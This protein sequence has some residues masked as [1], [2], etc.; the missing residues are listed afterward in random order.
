M[1]FIWLD[2]KL[3][4]KTVLLIALLLATSFAKD[5]MGR[6]SSKFS[7]SKNYPQVDIS[8]Y[9]ELEF[10][11]LEQSGDSSYYENTSEYKNLPVS[12]KVY[13]GFRHRLLLDIEGQINP[14]LYIRYK[15]MQEPDIPQETDIYVEYDKFSVYFGK[16]DASLKN[17]EIFSVNKNI[18]GI[19]ADYNG[20]YNQLKFIYGE[21][22]S[23]KK[24]FSFKGSGKKEYSLGQSN[25]LE[26]SLK[27]R[28]NGDSISDGDYA[29][30]YYEGKIIFNRI[31][32]VTE[33]VS[34]Y[35]EYLD[36]IEDFL[37]ISSKV[38]LQGIQ[39]QYQH[40]IVPQ[41]RIA[42]AAIVDK[43]I[44]ETT[45]VLENPL[46]QELADNAEA[47]YDM[48]NN[49]YIF[50]LGHSE[51][52]KVSAYTANN[53]KRI[54]SRN[55]DLF[56]SSFSSPAEEKN[57]LQLTLE[58][59][60]YS[61]AKDVSLSFQPAILTK[62]IEVEKTITENFIEAPI[63]TSS[64]VD[65]LEELAITTAID[66]V[67]QP[68]L[69]IV[70][71]RTI[72]ESQMVT[73]DSYVASINFQ[74][75]YKIVHPEGI[76]SFDQDV[77]VR[78]SMLSFELV[79]AV[80]SL[81]SVDVQF[82]SFYQ[83]ADKLNGR[84]YFKQELNDDFAIGINYCYL[85]VEQ[86]DKSKVSRRIVFYVIPEEIDY[87]KKINLTKTPIVSF[88]DTVFVDDIFL[89]NQ[90]DYKVDYNT[91]VLTFLN[92]N[93]PVSADVQIEYVYQKSIFTQEVFNGKDSKG[94]YEFSQKNIVPGT[95]EI[96]IGDIL[97]IEGIDYTVN[98]KKG[99]LGF[100][101]KISAIEQVVANYSYYEI[102]N[103]KELNRKE[104]KFNI[105]SF[106]VQES[107]RSAESSQEASVVL[108]GTDSE[109]SIVSNGLPSPNGITT[110][111]IANKHLPIMENSFELYLNEVLVTSNYSF[112]YYNG[113]LVIT[114]N[115]YPAS[116]ISVSFKKGTAV[117]APIK[118]F[119]GDSDSRIGSTVYL[120]LNRA[121]VYDT[122]Q[123]LEYKLP[124]EDRYR[125]LS[126]KQ[127]YV[128]GEKTPDGLWTKD[129]NAKAIVVDNSLAWEKGI[130]TFITS[131][132]TVDFRA[133]YSFPSGTEFR[134][135]YKLSGSE[136]PDPGDIL[137]KT[138]GTKI[139]V[140]PTKHLAFAVE[141]NESVKQYQRTIRTDGLYVTQGN[142]QSGQAL[143]L[144]AE[145]EIVEDSELVYVND[146]LMGRNDK[147][148][149]NYS[150]AYLR[151]NSTMILSSTDNIRVEFSYYDNSA[152]DLEEMENKGHA[153]KVDAM[154]KFSKA[155]ITL[156]YV[157]VNSN[158]D[159]V[160]DRH[161]VYSAGTEAQKIEIKGR[162]IEKMEVYS[163][164][165]KFRKNQ[166]YNENTAE[167]YKD[168]TKQK[169]SVNYGFNGNRDKIA[170]EANR[171]DVTL[172]A[173]NKE[174]YSIDTIAY[175]YNMKMDIGPDIFRT[176]FYLKN[177][178]SF[179][180]VIDQENYFQRY[181]FNRSIK[182]I[183]QPWNKL[184]FT[185]SLE[186]NLDDRFEYLRYSNETKA[187]SE[188]IRFNPWSFDFSAE[189]Q[190]SE[191]SK[192]SSLSN[193]EYNELQRTLGMDDKQVLSATFR[194]PGEWQHPVFKDLY[195]HFNDTYSNIAS[196]LYLQAPDVS[197]GNNLN[198]VLRP[199]D[200]V[201]FGYDT[202][203]SRR[204]LDNRTRDEY[205]RKSDY[206]FSN[207]YLT[208]YIYFLN[209]D[210]FIINKIET[211]NEA[212][213]IKRT[214]ITSEVNNDDVY[215][216]LY[217]SYSLNP[218][219]FLSFNYETSDKASKKHSTEKTSTG[220]IKTSTKEPL[221]TYSFDLD[222][223]YDSWFLL[224]DIQY[225]W[226]RDF[227]KKE[228][229]IKTTAE[230]NSVTYKIDDNDKLL[231]DM[232]L[233]YYI[234]S[235]RNKHTLSL[236]EEFRQNTTDGSRYTY[237]KND[238]F[239][240]TYKTKISG[241]NINYSLLKLYGLQYKNPN[242][243][244]GKN[245]LRKDG[246]NTKLLRY[247]DTHV[248]GLDYTPWAIMT[249]DFSYH[250]RGIWQKV[251]EHRLDGLDKVKSHGQIDAKSYEFG[252]TYRPFSSFSM[253]YGWQQD[254]YDLGLGEKSRFTV[255]WKPAKFDLGNFEYKYENLFTYGKGTNDPEQ[256][257]S[258]DNNAGLVQ[259]TVTD[260]NDI[261]VTNTFIVNINKDIANVIVD[262][263]LISVNLTRLH[264]WDRVNESYSYSL[265]AFYAKITLKF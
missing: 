203:Y 172:P 8:G 63:I 56:Q 114:G 84:Y 244:I 50:S 70:V 196:D 151:F 186:Q 147:Y 23:H 29:I 263:M 105:S 55:R 209:D 46:W 161:S 199:Y 39:H 233:L 58:T 38:R 109:L 221:Y 102:A 195:I 100:K 157:T 12:V 240:T 43:Y 44:R 235:F 40:L 71:T 69:P 149:I 115:S 47:R 230:D 78:G 36:P 222:L 120:D 225:I 53:Q 2:K 187:Y 171:T 11:K 75:G 119:L 202:R 143:N 145:K 126:Y 208:K 89:T 246:Y 158:Y 18:D 174:E 118:Y 122:I 136:N 159:P 226:S 91:G 175:D 219:D 220:V 253:R 177:A 166:S 153:V 180:D 182:N 184:S 87:I 19:Y 247:D 210:F 238:K 146:V 51:L 96:K 265:N 206:R 217:Q 5:P 264:F 116:Q 192:Q 138:Y 140:N 168:T 200:F 95:I 85:I 179:D 82:K 218:L 250:T 144:I 213:L 181:N 170:I 94:P 42:T 62:N 215:H 251:N 13:D 67:P 16:Y 112:S 108:K 68:Q 20:E 134:L 231:D 30:D 241:L 81:N 10:N 104:E 191:Y 72:I 254:V 148:T 48:E 167:R 121:I 137:H 35:Y 216:K 183:F 190:K 41:E 90:K 155:D 260:R 65:I 97:M 248:F 74:A 15:I 204:L 128:V 93:I 207:I 236:N 243:Q 31:I 80:A 189:V 227:T 1:P 117:N 234:G 113:L 66:A 21:E 185:T 242:L 33:V 64:D 214:A 6:G 257:S 256:N 212:S 57:K 165:E 142:G 125:L 28:I 139:N 141:Y 201:S 32:S 130:I 101:R 127:D 54:F 92:K 45:E 79:P 135:T 232:S 163:Y 229:H 261:L 25:I 259:T 14:K 111:N 150:D 77:F 27:I 123:S 107:A 98:Y 26:G 86:A 211:N 110:V 239:Y 133:D 205:Y 17:G 132:S 178:E 156:S 154:A 173:E 262:D 237:D 258:V 106:Y 245:E 176:N 61:F 164:V 59:K 73:Y 34:G 223:D 24:E 9:E 160:G 4:I 194:R 249:F 52:K 162:P 7:S 169:Y 193:D 99:D 224:N 188:L 76:I 228:M 198:A 22:R 103:K 197:R 131:N 124:G 255:N 88:S 3:F 129:G 60:K 252:T 152:S 83:K 49:S 37:P